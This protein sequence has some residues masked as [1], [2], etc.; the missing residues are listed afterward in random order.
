MSGVGI[1]M[2]QVTMGVVHLMTQQDRPRGLSASFAAGT[3]STTLR[4]CVRREGATTIR[5]AGTTP[6][7]SV[8]CANSG[9]LAA[10]PVRG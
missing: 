10:T 6:E 1:G 5:T 9:A 4:S 3:A 8:W 2:V 7:A